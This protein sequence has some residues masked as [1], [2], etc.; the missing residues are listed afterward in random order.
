[1][2]GQLP[3]DDAYAP[4]ISPD[5][6][7]VA[8]QWYDNITKADIFLSDRVTGTIERISVNS[9]E[10]QGDS[11]SY[12]PTPTPDL[13][14]VA[15]SSWAT[16]L[17][18]GD[19]NG[20]YPLGHDVFVRDRLNGTTERV[21]IGSLGQQ[22]NDQSYHPAISADGRY[23]AFT[24]YA[25]NLVAVDS[26]G[27]EDVFIRDRVAGTTE[28]VSL[29]SSGAQANG[30]VA[31]TSISADGRY[32]A[33]YGSASNLVAG[34][35]NGTMDVFVRDRLNGTTERVSV[36]SGGAQ[37][38]KDSDGGPISPDGRYV[39]FD[40][41]AKQP[42]TRRYEREDGC[43]PPRPP[44]G[45][46]RAAQR[47]LGRDAGGRRQQRPRADPRRPL[48][49]VP[50]HGHE[51]RCRGHQRQ[52][53]HLRPRSPAGDDAARE[54]RLERRPGE[55][56]Q[57][58]P[59][60]FALVG[61][62]LR[63]LRQ[64]RAARPQ[65][66]RTTSTTSTSATGA[67]APGASATAPPA[68]RRAAAPRRSP[69]PARPVPR[70]HPASSSRPRASRARRT[71]CSSS[72]RTASR[73]TPG[74]TARATS[75]SCPRSSAPANS[76]ASGTNGACDGAFAQDLNA[77]WCPACPAPHKNPG[78]GTTVQIQLWYRDPLNT[79]NQATSLSNGLQVE[80][81]P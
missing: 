30:G 40:S 56:R 25:T 19:T 42:G 28:L 77:Y 58:D 73:R 38:N 33:F 78:I 10:V 36:D 67:A 57:R 45:H 15:F 23:V 14:Y 63:G 20:P 61:R 21:S 1:M 37:G 81:C 2:S 76:Q 80:V 17:V 49:S 11:Y 74:A 52:V 44:D 71:A 70:P 32:V 8:F 41:T 34:D 50:E 72:A 65:R 24:S 59:G 66:T 18:A 64:P 55:R 39:A 5:G 22:G 75:A 29:D 4:A 54:R 46:D 47:R 79:S 9:N 35:T 3:N 7:Y 27:V 69:R 48:R 60:S 26:N 31:C 6:R 68:R 53:G 12:V 43:L 51:P 16:N 13:R 62:S